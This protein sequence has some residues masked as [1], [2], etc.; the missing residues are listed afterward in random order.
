MEILSTKEAPIGYMQYFLDLQRV[1]VP[2]FTIQPRCSLSN[3]LALPVAR[4][5]G[6]FP[7]WPGQRGVQCHWCPCFH[8]S[9]FNLTPPC[10]SSL[11]SEENIFGLQQHAGSL[12]RKTPMLNLDCNVC[13]HIDLRETPLSE[14][15]ENAEHRLRTQRD[16]LVSN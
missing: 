7:C 13:S 15:P 10:C 12:K 6:R 2:T 9:I 11:S 8:P 3:G 1:M 5:V 4:P 14:Q 16:K